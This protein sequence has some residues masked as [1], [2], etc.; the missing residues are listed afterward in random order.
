MTSNASEN[1]K[2]PLSYWIESVET[3]S[4]SPLTEDID[5]DVVIVGGGITGITAS[6]L[7]TNEG[8]SVAVLEADSV[9]GG[10]TGH[11][12]AKL[13]A[14]HDLI[15]DS[16]IQTIGRSNARLYYEANIEALQFVEKMIET[17]HIPCDFQKQ[18]A[19]L[20]A[21]MD[22]SVQKLKKEAQ[23]YEKLG[24]NGSLIKDIPLDLEIK[25]A[26]VMENQAQF[27][28]V[29][30]LRFLLDKVLTKNG[31]IFE[32]TVAVNVEKGERP[33]VLTRD[34]KRV[35]ATDV[36]ICSH[37]PFYEGLG[38]YSGR[39]YADRS[40]VIAAKTTK[41]FPGGMYLSI[42]EPTRS[43]RSVQMNGEELVLIIGE[44]HR[45]GESIDTKN[46]YKA[47]KAFGEEVFG[48][49]EIPYHWSTQDLITLDNIP[50]V[51]NI[52]SDV[53]NVYVA[54]GYRKWGMTNGTAAA[55]LLA[56]LV[57]KR[58]NRYEKLFAPAR[59]YANPSIK[60]FFL[61][62]ANTTFHLLK[63]KIDF[64]FRTI[65][66]LKKDEGA[67]VFMNG[68]RKGAYKDTEGNVHI[69][70]TTCTHV[71]CEVEWNNGER[72]WDCPC[73]GS[74]FSFTG[75]VIEGPAEKKLLQHDHRMMDNVT[76]E[77][78]GY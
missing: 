6:Y 17:H 47:L 20:Y 43:L 32:H 5:V 73:H 59:F 33:T 13:T 7:L 51:G 65:H 50:Y 34:G 29:K 26:L 77:D 55:L 1:R 2:F 78:S 22:K 69:V 10:T 71:G 60:N 58:K 21:T 75:E 28:P 15:Y 46:H 56:D 62:N 11:T 4:F 18:D 61:Q 57:L 49:E 64:P 70:D 25:R 16:F 42:D 53:P 68:H 36:L 24:I 72:S 27:H 38:L 48:I 39:M 9:F 30:Y 12:T 66:D 23:A 63:G 74:R 8:M 14:Q 19:F 52:T 31:Q 3:P 67:V 54:T 44:D 37:F 35:R 41:A 45:T 76:S 40:Y